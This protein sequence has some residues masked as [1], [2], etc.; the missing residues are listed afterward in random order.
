MSQKIENYI[1]GDDSSRGA[2]YATYLAQTFTAESNHTVSSVKLKMYYVINNSGTLTVSIKATSGGLP[3]GSDLASGSRLVQG[4]SN[5]SPGEWYEITMDTPYDLVSGTV[6]A[7]VITATDAS[8]G[9]R[10]DETSPSYSGGNEVLSTDSGANWTA[11]TGRDLMFEIW[12]DISTSLKTIHGLAKA[13]VK[14]INGL[15]MASVKSVSGLS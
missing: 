10:E 5:T 3:T 9:V 12:G 2:G 1:T 7:I 6:Y 11:Y 13:S 4:M 8:L 15:A 14:T